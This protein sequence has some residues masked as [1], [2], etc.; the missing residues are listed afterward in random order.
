MRPA[1]RS[2]SSTTSRRSARSCRRYLQRAGYETHVAARR[3]RGGGAGGRARARPRRARPDA[4][5]ASTAWRSMRRVRA[6]GGRRTRDH[7][8][9]GRAAR[10][11]T[12]S[13]ACAWAPTTTSSSRSPRPSSWRASTRCCGASTPS[14]SSSRRCAST[15]SSIDPARDGACALDGEEVVADPARVRPAAVPRPPPRPGVH[16]QPADG[17]RVGYSF[18]TDT[19]TVTVHIR[20]LRAKLEADPGAPALDRD[21]VGRRLPL[22]GMRRLAG[23][24]G[25]AIATAALVAA[26]ALVGYGHD[27]ALA[28]LEILAPLGC[29]TVARRPRTGAGARARRRPAPPVRRRRR[30]GD[31]AAHRGRRAVR[32]PD[33]RLRPRRVLRRPRRGLRRGAD[34]LGDAPR[35]GAAPSTTST[36]CARRSRGRRGPPRRAHRRRRP[37]RARPPRGRRRRHGGAPRR[38]GARPARAHRR[39][40]ARPAHADHRAAAAGRRDRRRPRRRRGPPRVRRAHGHARARARRADRRPLRAHAPGERRADVDDGAGAAGRAAA[41]GGRGDA[42]D[43]RRRGGRP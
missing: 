38:R 29:A 42:P 43:R 24:L 32:R 5:A 9:D 8:A 7:P 2:W 13:S 20:R 33:V 17:P 19:S 31:G 36:P 35:S 16:A 23:S 11:P 28:T 30:G 15:A 39:R 27:A 18:Y 6:L 41:R 25:F 14:P 21:G 3:R 1:A 40:L 26:V 4:A 12:A 37:R 34:R 22:R 10:S